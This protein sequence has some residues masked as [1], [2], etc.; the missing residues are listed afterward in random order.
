MACNEGRLEDHMSQEALPVC[1]FTLTALGS[2]VMCDRCKPRK[3]CGTYY[4]SAKHYCQEVLKP[5]DTVFRVKFRHVVK[6]GE[7][8]R[9][10]FGPHLGFAA[11]GLRRSPMLTYFDRARL[12]EERLRAR[13]RH[14]ASSAHT[15]LCS[16]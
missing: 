6:V 3:R 16:S 15:R 9:W 5:V 1:I 11:C 8:R 12:H 10:H 4:H 2:T 14:R 7:M 13:R